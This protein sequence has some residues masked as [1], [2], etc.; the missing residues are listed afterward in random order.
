[1]FITHLDDIYKLHQVKNE[2]KHHV[3]MGI[4]MSSDTVRQLKSF[5][6]P[7]EALCF[8]PPAHDGLVAQ[9]KIVIGITTRLYSDGR[10][11][12]DLLAR[13]ARD[14]RLDA[15]EFRIFGKGWEKI[16]SLLKKVWSKSHLYSGDRQFPEGL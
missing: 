5:G 11:R 8:I 7:S 10:K 9:K 15:F 16:I 4:C 1:M 14:L 13:L 2:L 3:D 6:V 12:E